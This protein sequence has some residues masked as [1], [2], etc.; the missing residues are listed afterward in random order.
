MTE[1]S[2]LVVVLFSAAL[3]ALLWGTVVRLRVRRSVFADRR[4]AVNADLAI[5]VAGLLFGLGFTIELRAQT[6]PVWG[7]WSVLGVFLVALV[8]CVA[9]RRSAHRPLK[10]GPAIEQSSV[11]AAPSE[12]GTP[13]SHTE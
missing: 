7:Q 11:S 1:L 3:A 9:A 4:S 5:V 13:T 12:N 2:A 10:P 6:L 8:A